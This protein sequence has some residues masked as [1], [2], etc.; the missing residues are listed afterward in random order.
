M[1]Q[2]YEEARKNKDFGYDYEL[3]MQLQRFVEECDRKIRRNQK[4]LEEIQ[5]PDPVIS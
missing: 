2:D 1:K 4:H 5:S 3:E